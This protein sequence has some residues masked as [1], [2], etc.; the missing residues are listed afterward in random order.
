MLPLKNVFRRF[1]I[2]FVEYERLDTDR[3]GSPIGG[4]HAQHASDATTLYCVIQNLFLNR[5]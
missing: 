2:H 4:M 5:K 1:A 3:Q